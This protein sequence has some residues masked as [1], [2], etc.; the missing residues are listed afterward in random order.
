MWW[1]WLLG[2][3]ALPV[4]AVAIVYGVGALL[5][6]DHVAA[7]ERFVP[8]DPASVAAIVRDVGNYP[9]WRSGLERVELLG[10]AGAGMRFVEHSGH[11]P[12]AFLL[13][14][15]EADARFRSTITN[16][17]L[18]F[19]GYWTITLDPMNRGTRVRIEEH[20]FV[21]DPL[22]RFFARFLF[23][24]ESTMRTWLDDLERY[25]R[26]EKARSPV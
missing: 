9:R 18:P 4:A 3:A 24:H 17:D 8:V 12:I 22:Y 1:K 21:S 5:P 6:R 7:A 25:R 2:V 15:E 26:D 20:G 13:V 10:R 14:E 23:G 19:G 11:D 16:P